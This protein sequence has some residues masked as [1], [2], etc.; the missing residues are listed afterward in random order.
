MTYVSSKSGRQ[1]VIVTIPGAGRPAPTEGHDASGEGGA[2]AAPAGGRVIAY[3][4]P[5]SG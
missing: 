3:A 2:V 5:E 1:Y 4:L